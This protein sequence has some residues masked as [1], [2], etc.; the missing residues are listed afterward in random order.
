MA[1]HSDLKNTLAVLESTEQVFLN[2]LKTDTTLSVNLLIL[3]QNFLKGAIKIFF[4]KQGKRKNMRVLKFFFPSLIKF[5]NQLL[6]DLI[7]LLG[8]G[9]PDVIKTQ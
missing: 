6:D 4:D 1:N 8:E 2:R 5:I 3:L 9:N 7:Q